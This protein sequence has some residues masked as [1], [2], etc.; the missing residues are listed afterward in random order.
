MVVNSVNSQGMEAQ[1][2][3]L[4]LLG[5]LTN[6]IVQILHSFTQ[7]G[8]FKRTQIIKQTLV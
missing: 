6:P 8:T 3:C 5:P 1:D 4:A 2:D 7:H